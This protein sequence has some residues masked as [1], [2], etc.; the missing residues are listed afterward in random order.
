MNFLKKLKD[1]FTK[2]VEDT[3]KP[4]SLD[5]TDF[6]KMLRHALFVGVAATITYFSENLTSIDF[7]A[8]LANHLHF[9]TAQQWNLMLVPVI[10]GVLDTIH[11]FFK[12]DK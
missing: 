9:L 4:K 2:N 12:G 8:L 1:V 3:S 10:S 7:G 6:V 5:S 11:K